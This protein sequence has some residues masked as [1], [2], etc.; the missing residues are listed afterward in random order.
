MSDESAA[1]RELREAHENAHYGLVVLQVSTVEAVLAELATAKARL[2][3]FDNNPPQDQIDV[4]E[5]VIKKLNLVH[6][7]ALTTAY[8]QLS[9]AVKWPH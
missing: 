1:V 2:A 5:A 8:E 3:W 7:D 4:Q 9:E 6:A